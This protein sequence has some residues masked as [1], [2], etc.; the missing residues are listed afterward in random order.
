MVMDGFYCSDPIFMISF[1]CL[2]SADNANYMCCRDPGPGMHWPRHQPWAPSK[3]SYPLT[4]LSLTD[5]LLAVWTHKEEW[6]MISPEVNQ[7]PHLRILKGLDS[8]S[9]THC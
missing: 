8:I 2:V 3:A 1:V 6:G 7:A 4:L 5:L 9:F